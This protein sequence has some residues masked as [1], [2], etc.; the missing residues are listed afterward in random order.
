MPDEP[1]DDV[2]T[3]DDRGLEEAAARRSSGI[4]R[5][6]DPG[7]ARGDAPQPGEPTG[8]DEGSTAAG[9][10]IAG[11]EISGAEAAEALE[12]SSDSD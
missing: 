6:D 1:N 10:P 5:T 8:P 2:R 3:P 12:R 9:T 4:V 11:R 7:V